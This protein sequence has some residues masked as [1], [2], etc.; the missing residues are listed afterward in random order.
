[1]AD[2]RFLQRVR[3]ARHGVGEVDRRARQRQRAAFHS[4]HVAQVRDKAVEPRALR[5][6]R[7]D[8]R[9][10][11]LLLLQRARHAHDLRER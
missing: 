7:G 10:I 6:E 8:Q 9:R 4:S 11:G 5:L 3:G 1:M 2:E